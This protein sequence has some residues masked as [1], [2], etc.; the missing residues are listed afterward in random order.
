MRF[1][2]QISDRYV[3]V[4]FVFDVYA[5][6]FSSH[7]FFICGGVCYMRLNLNQMY[8][9]TFTG[10]SVSDLRIFLLLFSLTFITW[11][12]FRFVLRASNP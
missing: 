4:P 6:V 3:G 9:T 10:Q 8:K 1:V 5:A 2:I 12:N 7:R 11:T